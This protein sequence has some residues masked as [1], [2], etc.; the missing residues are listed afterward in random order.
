[1]PSTPA[2]SAVS[3]PLHPLAPLSGDEITAAREI[4]FASGRAEVP[5]EA[6]RFAYVGL[7][8]PP[9]E[10]VRAFDRGEKVQVDRQVR[11]VL[12]QG[13]VDD[14]SRGHRAVASAS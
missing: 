9:K 13:P 1:M 4:V 12:L 7:C 6:L 3:T 11:I 2:A 14:V 5:N 10:L 8:D